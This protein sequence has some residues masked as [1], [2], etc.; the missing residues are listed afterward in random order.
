[1]TIV[2]GMPSNLRGQ[3]NALRVIAARECD[4]SSPA[5]PRRKRR[6]EIVSAAKFERTHALIVFALHEE[7]RAGSA[8]PSVRDVTTGVRF[9]T[10][11]SRCAAARTSAI[12][13]DF[14]VPYE[15]PS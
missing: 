3:R 15:S 14:A 4:D 12:V 6:Q 11:A 9:A 1:M 5:L 8:R 7:L 2:A 13:T 10:P